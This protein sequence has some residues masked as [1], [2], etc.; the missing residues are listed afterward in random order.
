MSNILID[1]LP[2]QYKGYLIN[3]NFK[4]GILLSECL[5]DSSFSNTEEQI[6]TA[7]RIL[8]GKGIPEFETAMDGLKW[9]LHG[10]IENA[11][12]D[13]EDCETLFSFTQDRTMIFSAFMLKYGINLNESN[14]HFFEFLALFND[15]DKTSFRKVIDLRAMKPSDMKNYTKEQRYQIYKLKRKYSL[16][17]NDD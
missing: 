10:G 16:E 6:Y 7:F 9:F 14:M 11:Q 1:P 8:Y 17:E 12:D 15:L 3:Y 13:S 4:S 5:S 2:T